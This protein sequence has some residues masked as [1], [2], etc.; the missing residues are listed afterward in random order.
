MVTEKKSHLK[1]IKLKKLVNDVTVATSIF[2]T[3]YWYDLKISCISFHFSIAIK[4]HREIYLLP[5]A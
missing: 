3:V 1:A 2:Y 5:I 4:W